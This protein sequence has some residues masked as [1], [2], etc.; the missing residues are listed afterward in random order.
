MKGLRA[1]VKKFPQA[2][3]LVVGDLILDGYIWGDVDRISPEAPVPVIWAKKRTYLPGGAANAANNIRS[4]DGEVC[5]VGVSGKDENTDILFAQLRKSRINTK[6]IFIEPKRHTTLKTRIIAGHQQVV[7][8]DWEHTDALPK[9]LNQ[10]IIRFI[11]KNIDGFDAIVIED[12][13]KGVIN[14]YLLERLISLAHEHKKIITVDPKEEHFQYY[15]GVTS[16]TPNRKELENAIRNL[17]IKDTTNRFQL[18]N[19]RLFTDQDI[20]SAAFQIL[21]YLEL[22]SMLVT[23][24]EQGMKLFEKDG[25]MKHI[26][27]VAQEVF[28]VS[29]AGDTVISAFTLGLCCTTAKLKAAHL[30]N[31]AAGIV[32]GKVGTAVV[33]R[34]ELLQRI[35]DAPQGDTLSR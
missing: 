21:K 9:E 14:M 11:Q 24:G 5:L 19:D 22:D 31:F 25:R 3:I 8:V 28:D 29:G 16:I 2:K 15:R 34:K 30:A 17:K 26:P 13:G 10:K 35:G 33:T 12:Y 1:I 18:N 20:D 7:R 27:T 23:L 4:L 6:G 32:V